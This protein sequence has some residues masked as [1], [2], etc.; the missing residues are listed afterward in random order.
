MNY[1]RLGCCRLSP[2]TLF[3]LCADSSLL[4][5]EAGAV[6]FQL[7][8]HFGKLPVLDADPFLSR[9]LGRSLVSGSKVLPG[10]LCC[11]SNLKSSGETLD[12]GLR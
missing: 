7:S 5:R 1:E 4:V 6:C 11:P 10:P 2:P 8:L 3:S 12:L 9:G